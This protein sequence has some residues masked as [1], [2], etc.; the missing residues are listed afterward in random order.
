LAEV[1]KIARDISER[2]RAQAQQQLLV[3]EMKHR[4][5]NSLATIQAIATQTLNR[6]DEMLASMH[7]GTRMIY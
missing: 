2:K 6:A 1:S 5:K 3:K 7:W 4:V